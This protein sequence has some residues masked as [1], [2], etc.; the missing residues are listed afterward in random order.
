VNHLL[1]VFRKGTRS[2]TSGNV[3]SRAKSVRL[4]PNSFINVARL[5]LSVLS[6]GGFDWTRMFRAPSC[7]SCS[8]ASRLAPSPIAT[9]MMTAATPMMIPSAVSRLRSLWSRRF[10]NPSRKVSSKKFSIGGGIGRG[11]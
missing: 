1:F 9:M 6:G 7:W 8:S 2:S 4:S 11:Q 10:F 5:E 3:R